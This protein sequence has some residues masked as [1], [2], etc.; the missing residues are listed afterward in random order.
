[1]N[2]KKLERL[3]DQY[4]SAIWASKP[5][6]GEIERLCNEVEDEARRIGYNDNRRLHALHTAAEQACLSLEKK[7]EFSW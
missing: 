5:N 3:I 7:E 6:V 1:M 2:T 4:E